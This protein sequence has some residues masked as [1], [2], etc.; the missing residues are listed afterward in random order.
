MSLDSFET[1]VRFSCGTH[2]TQLHKGHRASSTAG[3]KA[4]AERLGAKVYGTR[5]AHVMELVA[6]KALYPGMTRWRV[7]GKGR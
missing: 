7:F 2:T 1:I 6:D 3:P 4:A 5:F